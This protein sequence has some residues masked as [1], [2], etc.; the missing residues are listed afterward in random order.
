MKK[1]IKG[2][3]KI[4]MIITPIVILFSVLVY[5]V[6]SKNMSKIEPEKMSFATLSKMKRSDIQLFGDKNQYLIMLI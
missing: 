3:R 2:Y 5:M 1:W 4:V 6:I